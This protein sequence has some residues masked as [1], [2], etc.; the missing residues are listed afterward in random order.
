[1]VLVNDI[2]HTLIRENLMAAVFEIIFYVEILHQNW[3]LKFLNNVIALHG[4][5]N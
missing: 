5:N 4:V 3:T 1:M 2:T